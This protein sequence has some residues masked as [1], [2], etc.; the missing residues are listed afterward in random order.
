MTGEALFFF[1]CLRGVLRLGGDRVL[2]RRARC[3]EHEVGREVLFEPEES[4]VWGLRAGQSSEGR[5]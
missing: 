5:V 2:L 1:P 4:R 3:S